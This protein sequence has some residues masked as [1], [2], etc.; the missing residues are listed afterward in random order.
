MM[1]QKT[2]IRRSVLAKCWERATDSSRCVVTEEADL[3]RPFIFVL[4]L[5]GVDS[6]G[7]QLQR[8]GAGYD[9]IIYDHSAS[10]DRCSS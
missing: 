2:S 5:Q 1:L 7:P 9:G 10:V 8:L 4:G 6:S 3:S